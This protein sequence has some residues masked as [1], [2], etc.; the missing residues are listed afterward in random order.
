M[1]EL[2]RQQGFE[3]LYDAERRKAVDDEPTSRRLH[4][5]MCVGVFF[6]FFP[7]FLVLVGNLLC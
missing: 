3:E 4:S 7:A 6:F 1:K 5:C 2:L